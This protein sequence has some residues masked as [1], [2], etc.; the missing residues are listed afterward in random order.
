MGAARISSAP[1]RENTFAAIFSFF[2][3][4]LKYPELRIWRARRLDG[5]RRKCSGSSSP[6]ASR[7]L[8]AISTFVHAVFCVRMAPRMISNLP[9]AE[10]GQR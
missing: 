6:A 10:R 2:A 5:V 4:W 3:F 7:R 8:S 9:R 1:G